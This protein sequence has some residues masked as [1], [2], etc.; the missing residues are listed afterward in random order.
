MFR[1]A[2]RMICLILL[3]VS[4]TQAAT[5]HW[6]GTGGDTLWDNPA[7]W[8]TNNVPTRADDAYI[9]VPA[10]LAPNGPVIQEGME[11]E[12]H[13][14]ACEVAGEASMTMTGGTLDVADW[15]WWGDG[16]GCHGTFT[17]TGGT[18]T[19]GGEFELGWGG[20]EG[21]WYM[22]GGTIYPQELVIPTSSGEAG[23]LYLHGGAVHVGSDGLSMTDVGL[24]DIEEGIL[25]LEGD[26]RDTV[27]GY[28][29]QGLITAYAGE[30]TFEIDYDERSAGLTTVTAVAPV[31][32]KAYKP[33]M[34]TD[35]EADV[36]RDTDLAWV[37]GL[38]AVTH[39]VYLGT[40]LVD[41]NNAS[42]ANPLDVLIGQDVDV[43][44]FDIA[45]HLAFDQTYYW[46]IDEVNGAPDYTIHKGDIWSFTTERFVYPIEGIVATSNASS[47]DGQGPENAVNGSGL[48][49]DQHSTS[50]L[51]MWSANIEAEPVWIQF[52]FDR[53]YK[54]YEMYVW[55]HNFEF[56][57]LLGVGA[58]NVT[59]QYS[60]DGAQWSVLGDVELAQAPG[61][62]AY[63]YNSTIPFNGVPAQYV[64]MTVNSTWGASNQTG[65]S[66]V[67]ITY[68]PVHGRKPEPP[69]GATD[70]PVDVVLTWHPGREAA[71]HD[72]YL[73][74]DLDA[75]VSGTVAPGTSTGRTYA[76]DPLDLASVYYWRVDE[77]NEAEAVPVWGGDTWSFTTE[78]YI[79]IDDFDDYV[80]DES[81]GG[82]AI[83]STWIDG[84]VEFGGDP[85]NGGSQVGH[86]VSPFAEKTIVHA[87][88]QSMPLYFDNPTASAISEAD[89]AFNPAQDWTA[90]GI[91]Y[92][93]L[94]F[95]GGEGNTGQLY[96]KINDTKVSYAGDIATAQWQPFNIDL[97]T[98]GADLTDITT[99]SIGIENVGSGIIYIDDVRLYAEL[100]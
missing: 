96:V 83:W 93:Q 35:G 60:S 8:E 63:L 7:N 2:V 19:T 30:G 55:N 29:A 88:S 45:G 57:R 44:S 1:R 95:Y 9:D 65:L 39:D 22:T 12:I 66:E 61:D 15:I 23:Q 59:V 49:N 34:P 69:D 89:H 47:P 74:T 42:R 75:V 32:E 43:T 100:P 51:D 97:S 64:R 28:I 86:D 67:R 84:L 52:Q 27:N 77:V 94:W 36:Y 6:T 99:L 76:P 54:L 25:T 21:T 70:V 68:I 20:G 79:V 5:L 53:V 73:S 82:Q 3:L 85:D 41:V 62:S 13:G 90:S 14:L 98:V 11:A 26:L 71:S 17:M 10:A 18:I 72:I 92:L 46:R 58:K 56:E 78:T 16:D 87:G 91:Q 81:G 50:T 48:D 31:T 33:L 4:T 37:A 80:D 38:Y 40:D 24:I